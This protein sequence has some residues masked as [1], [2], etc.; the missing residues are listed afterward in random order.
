MNVFRYVN[1]IFIFSPGSIQRKLWITLWKLWKTLWK[2]A[3]LSFGKDKKAPAANAGKNEYR[4]KGCCF[5][6]KT[7][8][9]Y[10]TER[11]IFPQ[12]TKF[13]R[14]TGVRQNFA[15]RCCLF[16]LYSG[17]K[18]RYNADRMDKKEAPPMPEPQKTSKDCPCLRLR[19]PRH[20][21]C[22]ACMAYHGTESKYPV[23]CRREKRE[24]P[25][26]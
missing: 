4:P 14:S 22:A 8:T 23:A 9:L 1:G 20:G 5:S 2:P 18:N 19:C 15:L 24:K 13:P 17:E 6:G 11:E 12:S 3:S 7:D 10:A 16:S 21:D 26:R 25:S